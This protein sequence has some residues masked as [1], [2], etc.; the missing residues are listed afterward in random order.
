[1]PGCLLGGLLKSLKLLRGLLRGPLCRLCLLGSF[2]CSPLRSLLCSPLRSLLCGPLRSLL[3]GILRGP[4][5]N[6]L[7]GLF[8]CLACCALR[9][10]L[11]GLLGGLFGL[12]RGLRGLL[13]GLLGC[14]L[15]PAP[16]FFSPCRLGHALKFRGTLRFILLLE[17]LL[18]PG[19]LLLDGLL[20]PQTDL[21]PRL[22]PRRRE[23]SVLGTMQIGPGIER[24][25]VFRRFILVVRRSTISHTSPRNLPLSLP[26]RRANHIF[27]WLLCCGRPGQ[28]HPNGGYPHR[29]S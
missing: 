1:L 24:R 18:R 25:H 19:L 9:C 6:L 10:F 23:V 26:I 21:F 13:R 4:A 7:G 17:I 8:C 27:I 16:V 15:R 29:E 2:L 20:H 12:P 28:T 3:C 14:Q 11:R 22:R 5:G